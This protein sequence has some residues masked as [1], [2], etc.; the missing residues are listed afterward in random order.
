MINRCSNTSVNHTTYTRKFLCG[1]YDKLVTQTGVI[2]LL[3]NGNGLDE[4][5]ATY[6]CEQQSCL[7]RLNCEYTKTRHDTRPPVKNKYE[8]KAKMKKLDAL[9]GFISDG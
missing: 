4:W 3:E 8:F 6:F 1:K 7:K 9:E 5:S 2:D